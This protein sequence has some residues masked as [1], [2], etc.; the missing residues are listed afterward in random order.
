MSRRYYQ[1]LEYS[2]FI[3]VLTDDGLIDGDF[4]AT[5]DYSVTP[6]D[7][8]FQCPV[9]AYVEI[10]KIRIVVSDGGSPTRTEYGNLG[11]ALTNG[12]RAYFKPFSQDEY[13]VTP[14]LRPIKSNEDFENIA[15]NLDKIDYATND[16][17][18]D[19]EIV[20]GSPIRLD[21]GDAFIIRLN[22]DFTGLTSHRFIIHGTEV[23]IDLT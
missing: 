16:D 3:N 13:E 17:S 18:R 22:D 23:G 2:P 8:Y 20:L 19:Y 11:S 14:S 5:G 9:N 10:N 6:E 4:L 7:F 21:Q 1:S 12:V 15:N